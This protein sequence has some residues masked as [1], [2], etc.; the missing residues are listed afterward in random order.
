VQDL[1]RFASTKRLDHGGKQKPRCDLSMPRTAMEAMSEGCLNTPENGPEHHVRLL[2][3]VTVEGARWPLLP[4][5][6]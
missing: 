5:G 2:L 1:D 6:N 3:R 4:T